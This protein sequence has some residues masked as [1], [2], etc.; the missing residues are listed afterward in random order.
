M[1]RN[2]KRDQLQMEQTR[3]R[4]LEAGRE[5]ILEKGLNQVKVRDIVGRAGLGTGTFYF[6]FGKLEQ[7][8]GETIERTL[9]Q[10]R[11]RI[12]EV[13]GL[14]DAS[15]ISDPVTHIR[16]SFA[17]FIDYIDE[18]HDLALILLR[19]RCGG[20]PYGELIRNE[21]QRFTDDLAADMEG[22][23]GLFDSPDIH[24]RLASEAILGMTLQLAE[25]YAEARTANHGLAN[26]EQQQLREQVIATLTRISLKGLLVDHPRG[27]ATRSHTKRSGTEGK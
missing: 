14:S 17:L 4:L 5:V 21:F 9:E 15:G 19:E 3:A 7:F 24:P 2:P 18:H 13:R 10:L 11:A 26:R 22:A 12:R 23:A 8:L 16:R 27:S 6:H 25:R 20:G 1:G